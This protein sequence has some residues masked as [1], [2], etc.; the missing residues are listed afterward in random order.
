MTVAA[1]AA[2]GRAASAFRTDVHPE[3]Q[4]QMAMLQAAALLL[5]LLVPTALAALLDERL[6]HDLNG[7]IKPI[8]FQLSPAIHFGTL[9]LLVGMIAPAM[10]AGRL[11]RWSMVAAALLGVLEVAYIMVQAGRAR[12]SHFNDA[13]PFEEVAY[14][15]MGLGAVGLVVAT[16]IGGLMLWR[17]PRSDVAPAMRLAA[18]GGLMLSGLA[19]LLIAGYMSQRGAH[20]VGTPSG[21]DGLPLFGWSTRGGDLRVPHFFATHAAQAVPVFALAWQRLRPGGTALPVAILLALYAVFTIAV[22]VQASMGMPF[23]PWR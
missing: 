15:L 5:A 16:F 14:L 6:T 20:W 12:A 8:K 11:I 7:W 1:H 21:A 17:H 10:R 19:T 2:A 18:A 3:G 9:A 4:A 23:L 22:F 13:T